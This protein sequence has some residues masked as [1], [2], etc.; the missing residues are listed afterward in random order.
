MKAIHIYLIV[1]GML[2]G[3]AAFQVYR[4]LSIP[5]SEVMLRT[6]AFSGSPTPEQVQR[7]VPPPVDENAELARQEGFRQSQR[8]LGILCAIA[9]GAQFLA[10]AADILLSRSR[11]RLIAT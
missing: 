9:C 7:F 10:A 3:F 11:K 8:D 2:C 4:D 1:S 5:P 6:Y